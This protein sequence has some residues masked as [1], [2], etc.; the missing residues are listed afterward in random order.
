MIV[1]E[2]Y[3]VSP[4][5]V[6]C[7]YVFPWFVRIRSCDLRD[8]VELCIFMC[9]ERCEATVVVNGVDSCVSRIL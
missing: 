5:R 7:S 8:V 9:L 4:L 6:V 3:K 2:C 1:F